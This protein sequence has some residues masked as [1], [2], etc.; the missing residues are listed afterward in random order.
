MNKAIIE[1][2]QSI[3]LPEL[4]E[5]YHIRWEMGRN[6]KR[7][8]GNTATGRT[9]SCRYY[10]QTNSV[11]DFGTHQGGGPINF[12]SLMEDISFIDA[13]KKLMEWYN[14][15]DIPQFSYKR[16]L[17]KINA[18]RDVY[19]AKIKL[20]TISTLLETYPEKDLRRIFLLFTEMNL[21]SQTEFISM[22]LDGMKVTD[23][24]FVSILSPENKIIIG[25][26][27]DL[28]KSLKASEYSLL[29]QFDNISSLSGLLQ[30]TYI[31]RW[32]EE[33]GRYVFPIF[34]P[35]AIPVGFAGRSLNNSIIKYLT[36]FEYGFEKD[37]IL[38]GLDVAIP[39]IRQ[40]GY[41][42]LVEG[43]LDVLRCRQAGCLNTVAPMSTYLSKNQIYLLKPFT[44]KFLLAF[45][46]DYGGNTAAEKS[47]QNLDTF[48]FLYERVLL[49]DGEDPDS[50]GLKNLQGLSIYLRSRW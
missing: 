32:E 41:V 35:G 44:D 37:D 20:E 13:A 30:E 12:V 9:P 45:D 24:D 11:G 18:Q 25:E 39:A 19:N 2:L 3:P 31:E 28:I 26:D 6:F 43:I 36:R 23:K 38:Y 42:I 46:S 8:W 48:R 16:Y 33:S 7:P 10:P 5:R 17:D 1:R 27:I 21:H 34:L 49:P 29:R 40:R 47:A 50:Y 4:F 14:I 15:E 22:C